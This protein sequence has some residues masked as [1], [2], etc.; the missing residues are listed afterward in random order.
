MKLMFLGTGAAD[1]QRKRPEGVLE[2]RRYS[3]ALIDGVLLIDPNDA[4][5]EAMEEHGTDPRAVKYIVCTHRHRDH[6]SPETVEK[7]CGMGARFYELCDGDCTVMG[8][9]TLRAYKGNHGTAEETV[10]FMISKGD[11]SLYYALDGA[12]L[13]YGEVAAIKEHCPA[14]LVL[15]ATVGEAEGDYRIF[16]HND[17]RMVLEMKSALS[18]YV[19]RFAISHMARTLHESHALL[20][21]KMAKHGIIT[22]YDG[23]VLEI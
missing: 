5:I 10:H 22:A 14:L 23:L 7:L 2:Y 19:E 12:W 3:S 16:E 6:Y 1:W 8:E 11:K 18:S 15:D 17:L 13:M 9:Y 20:E 21:D 4:V